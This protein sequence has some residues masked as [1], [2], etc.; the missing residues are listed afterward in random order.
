MSLFDEGPPRMTEVELRE[1]L[2]TVIIEVQKESNLCL[3]IDGLDEFSENPQDLVRLITSLLPGDYIKICLSS[4]PWTEFGDAFEGKPS[5]KLEDLTYEDIKSFIHARFVED[6]GFQR[7]VKREHRYA[8][9]LEN[10]ITAKAD[11]VFLWVNLVVRS[12]L[13][14]MGNDNRVLDMQKRPDQ[15]PLELEDL[16]TTMLNSLQGFYFNRAAEYF[17][18]LEAW[19]TP[20]P[21]V[22]IYLIDEM[23]TPKDV[24]DGRD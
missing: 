15:L 12:L 1:L 24:K 5:L 23:E 10:N 19:E 13:T 17:R 7:L 22:L 6:P 4:R 9:Q 8:G 11:G 20:P 3:F 14:V 21:A 16:Y 18:L 2:Q